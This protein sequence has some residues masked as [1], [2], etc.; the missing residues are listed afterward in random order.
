M[1][2]GARGEEKVKVESRRAKSRLKISVPPKT[3]NK[4]GKSLPIPFE[5]ATLRAH[6]VRAQCCKDRGSTDD[7]DTSK[8]YEYTLSNGYKCSLSGWTHTRDYQSGYLRNVD[9]SG[10]AV[11]SGLEPGVLYAWKI[12]QK[13]TNSRLGCTAIGLSKKLSL[14]ARYAG[15]NPL[16]VNGESFGSTTA[17]ASADATKTG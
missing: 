15:T 3:I 5:S 4:R 16:R 12:Y 14:F 10:M 9:G 2:T 17:W 8:I 7:K 13:S 11:V 1:S 6:D